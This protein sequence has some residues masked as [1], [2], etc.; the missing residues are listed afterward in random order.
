MPL[1]EPSRDEPNDLFIPGA[2]N[3]LKS[4]FEHD[5][6][7]PRSFY[8]YFLAAEALGSSQIETLFTPTNSL[9]FCSEALSQQAFKRIWIVDADDTLWEENLHFSELISEF[10]DTA[11]RAG[12]TLDREGIKKIIDDLGKSALKTHGFGPLGFAFAL[13][14]SWDH[15]QGKFG[16]AAEP[17]EELFSRV[18]PYLSGVPY[19]IRSEVN[20]F[21]NLIQESPDEIA[22]LFT[23]GHLPIQARKIARSGLADKFVGI[24]I[25]ENKHIETYRELTQR[26]PFRSEEFVVIG[27]SLSHEVRPALE[28]GFTAFHLDNRNAWHSGTHADVD[29]TKY[30]RV[31]SLVDAYHRIRHL[32]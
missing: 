4:T 11:L 5:S 14:E 10:C 30:E 3:T 13:R 22:I 12:A 1:H 25:G 9:F 7:S 26:L 16:V 18:V 8:K 28:L 29:T 15:L 27:N 2:T 19:L 21:L 32:D 23:Q 24:A 6:I 17:P 20:E 31:D